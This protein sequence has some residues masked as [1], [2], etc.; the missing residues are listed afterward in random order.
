ME[1]LVVESE[2]GAAN[3][4]VEALEAAD[5]HVLRCHD[6]GARPFPCAGLDPGECPLDRGTVQVVLDVRGR[7]TPHPEPLEDGVTCALRRR[8][9]V[10]IAGSS[11]INPFAQFAVRDASHQD[12]VAA[13]EHAA[14]GPQAEHQ[15]VA[16]RALA[17]TLQ[18]AG[19]DEPG[20]SDV[21]R[22]RAGLQVTLF[23]PAAATART[24]EMAAVRVAGAV[25]AFDPHAA[26]IEVQC[27][28]AP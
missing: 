10:V 4:A 16:D 7:T 20:W 21:R 28:T 1:V 12:V 17:A 22:T 19:S 8:L 27:E 24:R 3:D 6:P 25:R 13:C 23:V 2:S 5:H 9:P 26:R 14:D 15:T 11:A 18:N